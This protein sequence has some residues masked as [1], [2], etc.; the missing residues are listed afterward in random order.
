MVNTTKNG[1]RKIYPHLLYSMTL[2]VFFILF[3]LLFRI[4]ERLPQSIPL[5]RA[6]EHLK[7]L[8]EKSCLSASNG[9]TAL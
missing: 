5:K 9:R 3:S 6:F 7:P 8:K 1:I 4:L 2:L